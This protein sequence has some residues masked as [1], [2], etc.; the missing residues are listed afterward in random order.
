MHYLAGGAAA[1]HT[2]SV[3]TS[4]RHLPH[5]VE[6]AANPAGPASAKTHA[7]ASCTQ[8]G[9]S[10]ASNQREGVTR[11]TSG[12]RAVSLPYGSST[13]SMEWITPFDWITS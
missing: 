6:K 10:E 7:H 4:S 11:H 12:P 5:F 13:L 3:T 1:D 9:K 8:N 2:P